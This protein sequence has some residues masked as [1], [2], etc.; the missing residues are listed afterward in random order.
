MSNHPTNLHAVLFDLDGV[1]VDTARY[2]YKA[3]KAL[4]DREGIYFDEAINERLKGVSRMDSLAIILERAE[5]NYS[6]EE[7]Q[8]MAAEKNALYVQMLD[9]LSPDEM[10]AGIPQLLAELKKAGIKIA[11]CSAS[12][13]T[14]TILNK[15]Q[16][17]DLF[18]AVVSGNDVTHSKPHPEGV[19]LGMQRLDVRA[20][21]T[22]LVEDAYA[23]IEAGKAAGCKTVGIGDENVLTNPDIILPD[24]SR[25]TMEVLNRLFP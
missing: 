7:K 20:D 14:P 17:A 4:A 15:L 1:V 19:L 23:G 13:N 21:H 12:K 25:L 6:E 3:W 10:L 2:H 22:V 11:V 16:I 24:T 8:Q 5:K 9:S 18:D